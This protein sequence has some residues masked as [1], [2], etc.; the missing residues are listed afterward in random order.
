MK[1][2]NVLKDS[3]SNVLIDYSEDK[4]KYK[5]NGMEYQDE[6]DLNH[7]DFGA[8]N[9][10]PALGRWMNIDPLAEMMRRHSPYNY[11]FNNPIF[12]I[13]PD[14]MMPMVMSSA[15]SSARLSGRRKDLDRHNSGGSADTDYKLNAN[16]RTERVDENDGSEK[17]DTDTLYATDENGNV[18]KSKNIELDKSVMDSKNSI[19]VETNKGP[20]TVDEYNITNDAKA[21]EVFEFLHNNSSKAEWSITGVG[22][23]SGDKG[24]NKLTTS[25]KIRSEAGAPRILRLGYTVRYSNHGHHFS[26]NASLGDKNFAAKVHSK[27]SNAPLRIFHKGSYRRY[28]S[29]GSVKPVGTSLQ[30]KPAQKLHKGGGL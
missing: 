19:D 29:N 24:K 21:K 5:F 6:L 22:N 20:M 26:N 3:A 11:A 17:N 1:C 25:G 10:N 7:Y 23:E 28:D 4:H 9:Y 18:D 14:G 27:F 16:G 30:M 12:F 13:D 2:G 8:R 15:S